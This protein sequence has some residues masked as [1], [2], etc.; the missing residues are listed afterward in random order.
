MDKFAEAGYGQRDI[1][2][3]ERPALVIVDFQQGFT[4]ASNPLGRSDHVQR[5]VDN[6]ALLLAAC[7]AKGIPVASC[8]VS[9]GGPDEMTYWKID[10]LY[11]GSFYHGHPC[12]SSTRAFGTMSTFSSSLKRRH[13]FFT[14]RRSSRGWSCIASTRLSSLAAR[15]RGVCA[16]RSWTASRPATVPSSLRIAVVIRTRRRMQATSAMWADAMPMSLIWRA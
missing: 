12:T 10:S 16:P 5:A 3:G 8:A 9:W 14:R 7:K 1:G 11:D 15:P 4:D 6:T 13:L 2:F